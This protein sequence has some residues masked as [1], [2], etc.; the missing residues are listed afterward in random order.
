MN[1]EQINK[2]ISSGGFPEVTEQRKLIETHI[3]WVLSCD[4]F[5]Y[6]IK[7][8]IKY[9]FLDFSTLE[10]RKFFCEKE[11]Q[12]NRRF[13]ED[14]Y[15]EVLPVNVKNGHYFIGGHTGALIDYTLKMRKLDT[16]KRMDLL[17]LRDQVGKEHIE[18]LAEWI[19]EFHKKATLIHEKNVLDLKEKFNDLSTEEDFVS[20]NLGLAYG[21]QIKRAIEASDTFLGNNEKLL[22]SRLRQGFFRDCHGD[23]HA[24]NI[25]LLPEPQP[26]DCLEF[27]D[28]YR[29]IDVLNEVAFLCMDL[30][31]YGKKELSDRCIRHYSLQFPVMRTAAEHRL[32]VY[33]KAYRANVRAKVS[34]LRAK[35]ATKEGEK[36]ILLATIKKYLKLVQGYM[37][38]LD[39]RV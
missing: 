22:M 10:R 23:L 31:A 4:R 13:A 5:V 38:T 29:Q 8:P 20:T 17:L 11:W 16:E 37:N 32:F 1:R 12:L 36:K 3:S 34:S 33:F 2:L 9:S 26:F 24:R 6:K 35:S 15:L 21:K 7:K 28:D 18:A 27:N 25:F 30:D 39:A 14:I 19:A